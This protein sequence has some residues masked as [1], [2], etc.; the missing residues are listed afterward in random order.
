LLSK[1]GNAALQ[2]SVKL[3]S[4]PWSITHKFKDTMVIGIDVFHERRKLSVAAIVCMYG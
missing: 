3:G 1:L 4:I 2:V